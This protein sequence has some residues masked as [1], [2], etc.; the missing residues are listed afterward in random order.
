MIN[1]EFKFGEV[2]GLAD[3][4]EIAADRVQFRNIFA[5]DNG[6]VAL[7]GFKNGQKLD[8][9]VAPAELLVTVLEGEIVFTIV[10][11]PHT[12]KAGEF[13]LVGA[14]VEHNVYANS[15]SKVMLVKVKP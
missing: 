1:T 11:K 13:L 10:D 4:V 2:H 9:H 3:Q 7:I 8:T 15:D 6:G 14:G 12:L 5:N